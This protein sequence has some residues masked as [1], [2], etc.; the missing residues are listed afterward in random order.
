MRVIS[1]VFNVEA[2]TAERVATLECEGGE[3]F[4]VARG[5]EPEHTWRPS[6]WKRTEPFQ[7]DTEGSGARGD[8]S[9]HLERRGGPCLV[10]RTKEVHRQMQRLRTRPTNLRDPRPEGCLQPLG[11][12][13]PRLSERNGEEAPHPAGAVAVGLGLAVLGAGLGLGAV[14]GLPPALVSDTSIWF[15]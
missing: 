4:D 3:R 5:A 10:E 7:R 9:D 8:R 12:A 1:P 6:L 13:Q 11:R 2:G 15:D 14:H